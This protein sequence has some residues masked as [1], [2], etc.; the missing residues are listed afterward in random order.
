MTNRMKQYIYSDLVF[1]AH[2]AGCLDA[3]LDT[4]VRLA[5]TDK[6]KGAGGQAKVILAFQERLYWIESKFV[7]QARQ[8]FNVDEVPREELD[9]KCLKQ[10]TE[11]EF[12][13]M[14]DMFEEEIALHVYCLT[15][16]Q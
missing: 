1:C 3:L 9:L 5:S 4:M 11:D 14:S 15:L 12:D 2:R 6:A 8:F 7:G 16:K 13:G 10:E